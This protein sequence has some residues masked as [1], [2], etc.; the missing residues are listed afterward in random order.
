M[1]EAQIFAGQLWTENKTQ[2]EKIGFKI[3]DKYPFLSEKP[4]AIN[5][6]FIIQSFEASLKAGC[7]F[8][9]FVVLCVL[10]FL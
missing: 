7:V 9:V 1:K 4:F 2:I 8:C 10:F 3:K 5:D 6:Q